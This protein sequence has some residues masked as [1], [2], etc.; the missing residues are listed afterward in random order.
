M[1][2]SCSLRTCIHNILH[3]NN[4]LLLTPYVNFIQNYNFACGSV[5][6]RNLVSGIN[7]GIQTEGVREQGAEDNILSEER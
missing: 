2:F 1:I 6:M 3:I 4:Q 7:G 5:L